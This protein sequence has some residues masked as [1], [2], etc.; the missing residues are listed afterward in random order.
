MKNLVI[1]IASILLLSYCANTGMQ[2][3]SVYGQSRIITAR[4]D[5]ILQATVDYLPERGYK[6]KKVNPETGDIETEYQTGAGL[7]TGFTGDKRAQVKVK[8]IRIDENQTK[9]ILEIFSEIRDPQS[10]WQFVA[11]EYNVGRVIYDRFFEAII[12]RAQGQK[13]E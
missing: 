5:Q 11:P 4:Y 1:L 8:V 7:G 13:I 12:A 10:G 9:L 6:I 3:D 2:Q